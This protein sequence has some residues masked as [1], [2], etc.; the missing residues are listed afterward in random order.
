MYHP[1]TIFDI[2]Y[3]FSSTENM[4]PSDITS[5]AD[6]FGSVSRPLTLLLCEQFTIS[7]DIGGTPGIN[8][9]GLFTIAFQSLHITL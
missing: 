4:M 8:L 6:P 1:I 9:V 2:E 3:P 7:E 5:T